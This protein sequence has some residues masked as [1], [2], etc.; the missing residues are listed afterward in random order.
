V[1]VLLC[2]F[3]LSLL[4]LGWRGVWC[5]RVVLRVGVVCGSGV[6]LWVACGVVHGVVWFLPGSLL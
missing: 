3:V 1:F 6:W 2:F 4:V 5:R